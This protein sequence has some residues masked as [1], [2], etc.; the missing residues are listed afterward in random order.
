MGQNWVVISA[1]VGTSVTLDGNA[2]TSCVTE[3]SGMVN[4]KSY[5]SRRCALTQGVH[6]LLGDAH[7]G[8]IAYGYGNAGSYAFAGGAFVKKIYEP[9]VIK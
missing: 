3:A 6:Q 8:I 1:E 9:P 4:N 5:E 7:F 2:T